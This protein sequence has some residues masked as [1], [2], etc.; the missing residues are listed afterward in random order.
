MDLN[1]FLGTEWLREETEN[2][3]ITQAREET[4]THFGW[5]S[6]WYESDDSLTELFN[7]LDDETP[8]H[9][10]DGRTRAGLLNELADAADENSRAAWFVTV[11]REVFWSN[12]ENR[13]DAAEYSEPYAMNYRYDKLFEVYEWEDP[14]DEG[15]WISQEEADARV[16]AREQE[17]PQ[18]DDATAGY[19][20]PVWDENWQML[21]R[22]GPDG[23]YEYAYSD[24]Q[25]TVRPGAEWLTY[26]QVMQGVGASAEAAEEAPADESTP[27]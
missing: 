25:Q 5:S 4:G 9:T 22:V 16:G 1:E 20:E 13:Y 6:D 8:L 15:V 2:G 23:V 27:E 7:L 21:Y 17:Q 14:Q 11:E 26:D 10:G 3:E 24:D 12:P 18:D 19:S